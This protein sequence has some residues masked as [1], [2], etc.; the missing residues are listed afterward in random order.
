MKIA[1]IG[2]GNIGSSLAFLL[3][4]AKF[5]EKIGLF[6]INENFLKLR[7]RDILVAREI[8]QSDCD[9]FCSLDYKDF[10]GFDI[11]VITAGVR[12]E[13]GQSRDELLIKNGE[14]ICNISKN[15][16]KVANNSIIIVVSN[17]VDIL[18]LKAI[19]SSKF[20]SNKVF[21]M[22]GEL[23]S[24]RA[25]IFLDNIRFYLDDAKS[26]NIFLKDEIQSILKLCKDG[27]FNQ[28]FISVLGLH[29]DNMFFKLDDDKFLKSNNFN[30]FKQFVIDEG[31]KITQNTGTSAYFA[32]SAAIYKMIEVIFNGGS[33]ICSCVGKDGFAYGRKVLV[34]R[35]GI[36]KIF[37]EDIDFS[38][39]YDNL[40]R[41]LKLIDT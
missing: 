30:V 23:D 17:P 36:D 40:K 26:A 35:N 21:G 5:C 20:S 28:N 37:D 32:P 14:I 13:V 3:L 7:T 24:N 39:Y 38:P 16:S 15:I 1:I 22:A 19:A 25:K 41:N 9:V 34:S 29:N 4:K 11:F 18:V 8:L 31:A 2:S 33:M 10:A 27:F 12:R 6:D